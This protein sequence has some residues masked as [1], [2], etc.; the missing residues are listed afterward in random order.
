MRGKRGQKTVTQ[1]QHKNTPSISNI[2]LPLPNLALAVE[3]DGFGLPHGIYC[4]MARHR[5]GGCLPM[6]A[7]PFSKRESE[8]VERQERKKK[9]ETEVSTFEL[10]VF[11]VRS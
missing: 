7:G 2:F 11:R 6:F 8:E 4:P 9:V 10:G 3:G 1:T 5:F